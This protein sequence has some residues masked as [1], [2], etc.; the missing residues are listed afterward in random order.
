MR[1]AHAEELAPRALGE[2]SVWQYTYGVYACSDVCVRGKLWG[3]VGGGRVGS[4]LEVGRHVNWIVACDIE[5]WQRFANDD[6]CRGGWHCA[7]RAV[8]ISLSRDADRILQRSSRRYESHVK[9]LNI[10]RF[11][12]LLK[13]N[14]DVFSSLENA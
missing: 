3:S 11:E 1:S 10:D 9:A 5:R 13:H 14:I 8:C 4:L 7:S 12:L 2:G 6:V